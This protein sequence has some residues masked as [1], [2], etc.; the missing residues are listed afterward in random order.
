MWGISPIKKTGIDDSANLCGH[1]PPVRHVTSTYQT[2]FAGKIMGRIAVYSVPL[3]VRFE[4]PAQAA[5]VLYSAV[6]GV[7]IRDALTNEEMV[8]P[9][10]KSDGTHDAN[11]GAAVVLP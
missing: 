8:V 11:L 10:A 4:S 6:L 9:V 7:R 2:A 5:P 3:I 1:R